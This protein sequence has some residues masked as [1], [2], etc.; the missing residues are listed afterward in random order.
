MGNCL[1]PV[2]VCFTCICSGAEVPNDSKKSWDSEASLPGVIGSCVHLKSLLKLWA[3]CCLWRVTFFQMTTVRK[4]LTVRFLCAVSYL[5]WALCSL[6]VPVRGER[7]RQTFPRTE[8]KEMGCLHRISF[9]SFLYSDKYPLPF[10]EPYG[11]S[12]CLWLSLW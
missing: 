7:S 6:S 5:S 11:K 2:R 3:F 8:I 1:N 12:D 10:Y 4:H 9:I